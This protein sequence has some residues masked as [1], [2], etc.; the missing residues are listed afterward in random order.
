MDMAMKK[1][2][3]CARLARCKVGSEAHRLI[4]N[5]RIPKADRQ[6]LTYLGGFR[7]FD[8]Y[9]N[10]PAEK[11]QVRSGDETLERV[12][13]SYNNPVYSSRVDWVD[14]IAFALIEARYR[15]VWA[16]LI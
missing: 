5:W 9:I 7:G 2:A 14:P 12:S 10:L 3:L 1:R 4:A 8:L 6:D 16:G 13:I 15:A 11:L